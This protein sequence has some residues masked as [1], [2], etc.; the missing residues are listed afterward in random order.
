MAK[1][2]PVVEFT[3][4]LRDGRPICGIVRPRGTVLLEG[5]I[6]ARIVDSLK[7]GQQEVYLAK[8]LKCITQGSARVELKTPERVDAPV[9]GG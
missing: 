9:A 8:A 7:L 5:A 2:K 1:D 4:T 6:P 3:V